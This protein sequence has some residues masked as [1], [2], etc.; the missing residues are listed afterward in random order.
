M[1]KSHHMTLS[2]SMH[3]L[4]GAVVKNPP[5]I[6]EKREMRVRSLSQA[7]PL[8]EDM[9]THSSIPA[10]KIPRIEDPGRL[11]FTG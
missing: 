2:C 4:G 8:E 5:A 7:D 3:I 11:Q 9:A 6:Q 1:V 10:Y